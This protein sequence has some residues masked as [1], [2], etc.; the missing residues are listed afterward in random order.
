LT[1]NFFFL[2]PYGTFTIARGEDVV[3]LFVFLGLSILISALLAR[4]TE[5]AEA[6]EAREQELR[7]LQDLSGE[8]VA[9]VPGPE[10]YR[11]VLAHLLDLFGY[12]V[13]SLF[14]QDPVAREL[15]ERVT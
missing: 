4:S 7:T 9:V 12:S 14:V 11:S 1:F 3:V 15:R 13:A 6:A 2:P 8:L 10:S 5:R